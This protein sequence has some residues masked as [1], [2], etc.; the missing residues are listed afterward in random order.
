MTIEESLYGVTRT[1]PDVGD[2]DW[3]SEMQQVLRD[4]CKGLNTLT[5]L[6]TDQAFLALPA[7]EEN[8]TSTPATLTIDTPRS[9]LKANAGT[10]VIVEVTTI[11]A[12]TTDGQLALLIGHKDNTATQFAVLEA[13]SVTN[14][15]INGNMQLKP[16]A[17]IY[18]L[19]D[20]SDPSNKVW[21]ELSRST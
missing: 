9:N 5:T 4:L 13:G 19:W 12:G 6:I 1:L 8:L 10:D 14:A 17:A 11:T 16:G 20:E 2:T 21:R 15:A 3:G 18:L 7:T